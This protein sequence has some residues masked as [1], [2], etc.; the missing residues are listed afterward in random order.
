M[1]SAGEQ[2]SDVRSKGPAVLF[3]CGAIAVLVY[4]VLT[5]FWATEWFHYVS[6]AIFLFLAAT[7]VYKGLRLIAKT[8]VSRDGASQRR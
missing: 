7:L 4:S 1:N 2:E 5:F 6:S 3:I 8:H